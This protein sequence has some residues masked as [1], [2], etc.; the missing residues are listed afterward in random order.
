MTEFE[1][2]TTTAKVTA[3]EAS[4]GVFAGLMREMRELSKKK[5]DATLSKPKVAI[6][7]RILTDVLAAL[8][9]EPEARYLDL[10]DDDEL[11]Q[12]SDAVLVMV[13]YETALAAFKKRYYRPLPGFEYQWITE[14]RLEE[15]QQHR[16][17]YAD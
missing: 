10:L 11:P 2:V 9:D 15:Y 12:N 8:E 14:E 3:F 7:N 17:S 6:L 1:N 4:S 16:D 13:Q 5:P